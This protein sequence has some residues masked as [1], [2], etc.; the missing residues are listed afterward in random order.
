MSVSPTPVRTAADVSFE[1]DRF[2]WTSD[3][4][5][6]LTGRWF[7]VRGRRF[8]R[9]TL[10]VEVDGHSRRLLA[11]LEHKPWA[12]EDGEDWQAAFPWSGEPVDLSASLAV[13]SDVA[14]PLPAPGVAGGARPRR[15]RAPVGARSSRG[16]TRRPRKQDLERELQALRREADGELERTRA[17]VRSA[18][19]E[20]AAI[21][22]EL[23]ATRE[24]LAAA[25]AAHEAATARSD[26]LA[27]ERDA[28]LAKIDAADAGRDAAVAERDA[29]VAERGAA[30][31]A[32][33]SAMRAR[34]EAIRARD[35]ALR[36]R[37]S[38]RV[39]RNSWLGRARGAA[40][41]RDAA[42]VE[43]DQAK[44]ARDTA[45][46]ERDAAHQAFEQAAR[47]A[48]AMGETAARPLDLPE[49]RFVSSPQSPD[50]PEARS[51]L[52]PWAARTGAVLALL[53]LVV[54]VA[55]LVLWA[56]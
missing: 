18:E 16:S 51:R 10:D 5:I 2:E 48:R 36:D 55:L 39:E 56:V 8:L 1:V 44:A 11:L 23:D 50:A 38:V 37:D 26:E 15:G 45:L 14:V 40:A 9:P 17:Q 47:D 30:V 28:A 34:E 42:L 12:A 29:A 6:E 7:G 13:G 25:E 43:R 24:R 31:A 54:L 3:A 46:S 22:A 32:R 21:G 20:A 19:E 33:D 49:P 41:Q 53:L 52:A 35:A 27:R 4:R